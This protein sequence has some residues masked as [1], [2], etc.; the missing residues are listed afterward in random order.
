VRRSP[1]R[2]TPLTARQHELIAEARGVIVHVANELAK[3]HPGQRIEDL[4]AWC[5]DG[6][7][8]AAQDF[9]ED[10]EVDRERGKAK[11]VS[12]AWHRIWGA[13]KNGIGREG[14]PIAEEMRR[15]MA[16][17]GKRADAYSV[18]QR[19]TMDPVHDTEADDERRPREALD[20]FATGYVVGVSMGLPPGT[21]E[22]ERLRA[23]VRAAVATLKERDETI[24]TLYLFEKMTFA[25][26][27]KRLYGTPAEVTVRRHFHEAM[28]RLA[29]RL[30]KKRG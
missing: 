27:A 28:R 15:A 2:D 23:E 29:K 13:G 14:Q 1:N 9:R 12:Y 16:E 11:F 26:I 10:V 3:Q 21:P 17:G 19:D 5:E 30:G 18:D 8:A 25:A 22:A 4:L 7:I 6:A 24:V 20:G